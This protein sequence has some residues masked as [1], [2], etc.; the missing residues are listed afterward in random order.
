[1][2]Q[3][4]YI[5]IKSKRYKRRYYQ[6]G[7]IYLFKKKDIPPKEYFKQKAILPKKPTLFERIKQWLM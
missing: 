2:T 7:K 6:K 3:I 5:C 1:M 4:N